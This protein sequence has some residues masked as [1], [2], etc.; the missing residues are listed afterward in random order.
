MPLEGLLKKRELV[1]LYSDSTQLCGIIAMDKVEI[2]LGPPLYMA[3]LDDIHVFRSFAAMIQLV[4]DRVQ[5]C[6]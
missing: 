6:G 1:K 2:H 4:K 5:S 3:T